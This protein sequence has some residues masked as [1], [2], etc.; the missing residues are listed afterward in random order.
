VELR[1]FKTLERGP[2][3]LRVADRTR[4]DV[5]LEVGQVTER[6]TVTANAPLL[7]QANADLG[8]VVG[9]RELVDLPISAGNPFELMNQAPGANYTGAMTFL[10]PANE[11][12]GYSI[13]GGRDRTF[14]MFSFERYRETLPQAYYG[15]VPTEEQRRGDFSKTLTASGGLYTIYDSTTTRLNPAYD[16]RRSISLSNLQYIRDPFAGNVVPAARFDRIA[17]RM[18]KD[19]PLPNQA[20]D[21]VTRLNN[22]MGSQAGTDEHLPNLL[23]RGDHVL[24]NSWRM[25]ARWTHALRDANQDFWDWK[26]PAS[27]YTRRHRGGDTAALD[28]TATITP[29][30][31]FTARRI[32]AEF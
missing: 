12:S 24:S 10:R 5:A 26:T 27:N 32:S 7:E 30:T 19:I 2:I 15:S 9:L 22:W 17:L 8:Q 16:S 14:W 18:L 31:V 6:I 23:A 25:S 28:A 29:R 11:G 21:A 4:V 20:G 13:N 3:E 1:G